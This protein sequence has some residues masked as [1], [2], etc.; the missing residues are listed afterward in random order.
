MYG[1]KMLPTPMSVA[2]HPLDLDA[3]PLALL[4]LDGEIVHVFACDDAVDGAV[5]RD[6]LR[7]GESLFGSFSSTTGRAPTQKVLQVADAG[8]GADAERHVRRA[9]NRRRS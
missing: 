6:R 1:S 4:G 2:T 5:Q 3:D 7:R 8:R 9:G